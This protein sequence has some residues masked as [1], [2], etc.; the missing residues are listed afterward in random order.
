[1]TAGELRRRRTPA[2]TAG[3]ICSSNRSLSISSFCFFPGGEFRRLGQA[4]L[5]CVKIDFSV[6]GQR[7][8]DFIRESLSIMNGR[9]NFRNRP[10]E[11]LGCCGG[12]ALVTT[13]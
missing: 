7:F 1:M 4:A 5:Q 2:A 6:L 9:L 12:V 3:E 10:A 13:D 11:M 8:L